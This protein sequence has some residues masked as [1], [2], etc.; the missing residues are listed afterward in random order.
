MVPASLLALQGL[1]FALAAA[2]AHAAPVK[3]TSWWGDEFCHAPTQP[4]CTKCWERAAGAPCSPGTPC[5][6]G[7]REYTGNCSK[8]VVQPSVECGNCFPEVRPWYNGGETGAGAKPPPALK[9]CSPCL[10]RTIEDYRSVFNH[11]IGD[12]DP[13]TGKCTC[14]PV[15]PTTPTGDCSSGLPG[16]LSCDCWCGY[17][18]DLRLNCG[19]DPDKLP[20]PCAFDKVHIRVPAV[21]S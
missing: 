14:P 4:A 2:S 11:S 21:N 13:K 17:R 5:P 20:G 19:L 7:R 16:V 18:A 9:Q 1:F 12:A 6:W 15:T 3:N 10:I 8:C